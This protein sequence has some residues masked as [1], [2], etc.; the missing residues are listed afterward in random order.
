V[1]ALIF[2]PGSLELNVMVSPAT[3]CPVASV[4]VTVTVEV[5]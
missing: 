2:C 3:G 5:E 4:A 1:T